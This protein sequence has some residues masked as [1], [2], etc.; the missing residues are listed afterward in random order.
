MYM[1]NLL[2]L[3]SATDYSHACVS[4]ADHL[5]LDNQLGSSSL[6]IT[7]LLLVEVLG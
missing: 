3:F 6:G 2:V 7:T 4:R 5:V 1:Y